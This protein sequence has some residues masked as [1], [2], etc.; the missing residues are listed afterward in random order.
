MKMTYIR[1]TIIAY[2]LID[3][4]NWQV[5]FGKEIYLLVCAKK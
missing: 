5:L 4:L 1:V 2:F 3:T